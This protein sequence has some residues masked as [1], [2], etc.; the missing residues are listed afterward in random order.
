MTTTT[1]TVPQII[2]NQLGGRR[3]MAMT[4]AACFA[5]GNSLVVKFKGSLKANFMKVTLNENDLY[6]VEIN[7]VRGSNVKQV[8]K[9]E[10]VYNDMLVEIFEKTTGLYT[11]I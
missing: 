8:E 4:G 7:L 1:Q 10:D 2:L 6:D 3:F 9:V 5:D 11:T